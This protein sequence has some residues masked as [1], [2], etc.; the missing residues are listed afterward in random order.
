M[1]RLPHVLHMIDG[2]RVGGAETLLCNVIASM[3]HD[4]FR[5]SVAYS[6]PG[7][8]IEQI[9][10]LG[11]PLTRVPRLATVDPL[12]F[13][14]IYRLIQRDPPDILH[15]HLFKSDFHGRPAARLAGVPVVVSALQN[16]ND[17]AKNPVLGPLYGQTARFADMLIAASEEVRQYAI[18]YTGVPP[19]KVVTIPNAVP[20]DRF[21]GQ[22]LAGQQ[23][24]AALG[25]GTDVPLVGIIAR[26]MPQKDHATFLAAAALVLN[27]L[28]HARFLIAGDG[29]LR[30]ALEAQVQSLGIGHAVI[31]AGLRKDIPAVLA[32]IDVLAFS[33][34]WEGLPIAMLEGMASGTPI[35]A[36]AVDGIPGV[37]TSGEHGLL[38]PSQD[39][40]ALAEALRRLLHDTPFAQKLGANGAAHVE[41]HYS[42]RATVRQTVD[43][44]QM[45]LERARDRQ[46]RYQMSQ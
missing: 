19:E 31:F 32:A 7:P 9:A 22:Q 6:T 13:W 17:W 45:L 4:R 2:L 27:E 20:V 33:S 38:V 30:S 25:I 40:A 44:Y 12:F 5:V 46:T 24:R 26:L 28:P 21:Q 39:P 36:T 1:I 15:T 3:P 35:V 16:C 23:V 18:R 43:L 34:R 8:L 37:I 42:I 41:A 10:A 29:P 14:K 11:V